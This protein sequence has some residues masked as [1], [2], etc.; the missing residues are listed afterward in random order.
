MYQSRQQLARERLNQLQKTNPGSPQVRD[1]KQSEERSEI[2][3]TKLDA[4]IRNIKTK[5]TD[6]KLLQIYRNN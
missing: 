3:V 5:E 1:L 4:L 2:Q 6:A